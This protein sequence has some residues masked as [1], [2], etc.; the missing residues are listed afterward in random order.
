MCYME[1]CLNEQV[2]LSKCVVWSSISMNMGTY[3][4]VLNGVLSQ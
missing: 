2:N 3:L 4:N 1:F